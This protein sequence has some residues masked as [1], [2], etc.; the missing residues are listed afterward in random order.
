M[1]RLCAGYI[2]FRSDSSFREIPAILYPRSITSDNFKMHRLLQRNAL[3]SSADRRHNSI[4]ILYSI[5]L[6]K[7]SH[8]THIKYVF[9]HF[10][11]YFLKDISC[12][13]CNHLIN[14]IWWLLLY[15]GHA[16]SVFDERSIG[17]QG[18]NVTLGGKLRLW[19][20]CADPQT[21]SIFAVMQ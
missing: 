20:D 9:C 12:W 15:F 7:N 2:F 3:L 19:S 4:N 10:A 6:K 21:S 13:P 1:Q 16:P 5:S 14:A 17:S 11:V 18:S 8:V